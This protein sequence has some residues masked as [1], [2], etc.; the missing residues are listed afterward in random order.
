MPATVRLHAP[1]QTPER[2]LRLPETSAMVGLKRA[3]IYALMAEGRFP[4]P[5]RLS[6]RAVAWRMSDLQRWL[7]EREPA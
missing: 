1:A 6:A 3:S 4:R 2:V 5:V 7:S